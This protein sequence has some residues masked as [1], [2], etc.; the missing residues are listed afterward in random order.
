MNYDTSWIHHK[1]ADGGAGEIAQV[2]FFADRTV[3]P[4]SGELERAEARKTGG[5]PEN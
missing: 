4:Q 1:L 5:I 2:V 3:G